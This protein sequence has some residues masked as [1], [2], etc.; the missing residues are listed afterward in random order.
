MS[1][2]S[3]TGDC[4]VSTQS[5]I[6]SAHYE[7]CSSY[8]LYTISKFRGGEMRSWELELCNEI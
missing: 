8:E 5:V 7:R 6:V 3:Q 2:V 1:S 4:H